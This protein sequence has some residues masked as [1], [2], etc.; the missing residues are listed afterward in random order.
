MA[1]LPGLLGALLLLNLFVFAR[2]LAYPQDLDVQAWGAAIIAL[3][4]V[5]VYSLVGAW[6]MRKA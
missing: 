1:T 4:P 5:V 3:S 6:T 2:F